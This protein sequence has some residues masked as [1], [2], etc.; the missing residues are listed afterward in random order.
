LPSHRIHEIVGRLLCGYSSSKIDDLIDSGN[1]H[2]AGRNECAALLE[3]SI[4]VFRKHGEKGLCYYIL[5]HYLDKIE[6]LI[7]ARSY[8]VFLKYQSLP[9]QERFK[10]LPY[11]VRLGLNDEVSTLSYI[12]NQWRLFYRSNP[13]VDPLVERHFIYREYVG[14]GYSKKAA[15]KKAE[16]KV[17]VIRNCRDVDFS[18]IPQL[19]RQALLVRLELDS[20]MDKVLCI[21]FTADREKWFNYWGEQYYSYI[22]EAL[23]CRDR[24][25]DLENIQ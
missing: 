15:R 2:D 16:W 24:L 18:R 13:N 25:K 23:K 12:A 5:H 9:V 10:Y 11:E 17:A 6:T 1:H 3:Q 8:R 4:E 7:R 22:T 20:K 19:E 14:R 21:M